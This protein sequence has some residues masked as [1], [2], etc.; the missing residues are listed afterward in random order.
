MIQMVYLQLIPVKKLRNKKF[1]LGVIP[2]RGGSKRLP[3][4]NILKL[5]SKP[6][7]QYSIEAAQNSK[8]LND[9]VFSTEDNEIRSI[10]ESIIGKKIKYQRPSYFADDK[11]RNSE[12]LIHALN[13]YEN[14]FLQ[15]VYAVILLQPTTPFRTS[16]HID[17]AINKFLKFNKN[18][19]ASVSGPHKKRDVIIKKINSR[20]NLVNY[21]KNDK[22]E[23]FYRLNAS[24]YI[25]KKKYLLKEKKFT[26]NSM[27]PY[28]MNE[29]SS[30]DIDNELDFNLS[31]AVLS[32]LRNK[33]NEEI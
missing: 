18:V 9:Y 17:E 10:A 12:T 4:K 5:D 13:W 1:F 3:R 25:V 24:I 28:I 21:K 29:V 7:I 15:K 2:A 33:N 31:K 22:N 30:I 8:L 26:S 27:I 6:L 19:L 23:G 16:K 14:E 20:G 11:T 32:T